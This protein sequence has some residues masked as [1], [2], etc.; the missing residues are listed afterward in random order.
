MKLWMIYLSVGIVLA[1]VCDWRL[2][3]VSRRGRIENALLSVCAWPLFAPFV[4]LP[5]LA[6]RTERESEASVRI[7]RAIAE[8]RAAVLG[9]PLAKLLPDSML[10]RL[11]HALGQ[12]EERRTEL[13]ELLARPDFRYEPDPARP[14]THQQESVARLWAILERDRCLLDE[15]VELAEALRAQLLL[16]RYSGK[17]GQAPAG[18][19]AASSELGGPMRELALELALDLSARVESLNAWFELESQHSRVAV[20]AK[21]AD[22]RACL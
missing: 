14:V 15:M 8:A 2:K 22:T 5:V 9:T 18:Y 16:A 11:T 7:K 13:S 19:G 1:A 4:L 3:E 10:A 17:A 12:I 20:G 6:R 21:E